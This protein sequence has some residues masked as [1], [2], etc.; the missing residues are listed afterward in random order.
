MAPRRFSTVFD[1][2]YEALVGTHRI[3][4]VPKGES[5]RHSSTVTVVV[6]DNRRDK[7]LSIEASDVRVDTFRASGPGGQHRNKTSSGVRLTH[8]PSGTVVTAVEDRSQH[9]NRKVAWQRLSERMSAELV[10]DSH[11]QVNVSRR[12]QAQAERSFTWTQW[13]NTVK[14]SDGRKAPMDTALT[15]RFGRLIQG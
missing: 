9:V 7:K 1:P 6:L 3:Q 8:L 2:A 10:R 13:R 5:R 12:I 14:S 15:G 11:E 4:R